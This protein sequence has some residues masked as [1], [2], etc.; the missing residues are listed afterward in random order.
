MKK[1]LLVAVILLMT[2]MLVFAGG[3]KE[4]SSADAGPAVLTLATGEWVTFNDEGDK[5][6]STAEIRSVEETI[7]GE[8]V[9]VHYIKG[10]VT[11]KFQYGFAG[12]GLDPD[13]A[14]LA[15]YKTAKAVSFWIL[16]DGKAY[17]IK[18][19]TSNVKDYGYKEFRFNTE[20][21]TPVYVEVPM[22]LFQSPSWA[23]A[24]PM[25]QE[26]VTGIEWQTHESW[27]KPGNS[28]PFEVKFYNFKVHN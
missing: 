22:Y 19:K 3:G 24:V 21:G 7:D 6:S 27:R 23:A 20:P 10:N 28:N 15:L 13:D 2:S 16:G 11:N 8:K 18:Y 17:S 1:I 5:G 9:M 4:K 26:L 12:W 14:T 25:K